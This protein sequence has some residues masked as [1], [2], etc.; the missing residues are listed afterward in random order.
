[1]P[2][3]PPDN[4]KLERLEVRAHQ[5]PDYSD[6]PGPDRTFVAY[7]NPAEIT[8]AFEA[9]YEAQSGA[10][11]TTSR[12]NFKRMKPGDLSLSF[13]IDGTGANGRLVKV[14]DEIAQFHAVAGYN[15]EIHRPN[16]L[17]VA[18]GKVPPRRCVLKSASI[19]Y[20]LFQS[21]GVPLRAI[22]TATF[23]ENADDTTR[24]ATAQDHSADLTH[25]RLVKAGDSL[26]RLCEEIYGEPRM[27]L[28]VAR[29]NGLDNFRALATGMR[30]A[31]P[32]LE[33]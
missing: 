23:T 27:Y 21:D 11:T 3:S 7:V 30:L 32:P 31:F 17:L 4:G 6:K 28:E 33:K 9:E 15:G 8:Y 10:G 12:Q 2:L 25:V 5:K 22:I 20:K 1:M 18:Y 14:E 24:V 29:A 13:F 26:P 19:V 16:Y